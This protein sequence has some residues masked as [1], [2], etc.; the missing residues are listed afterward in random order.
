MRRRSRSPRRH[1]PTELIDSVPRATVV[2][3][4]YVLAALSTTVPV[5]DFVKPTP[6]VLSTIVDAMVKMPAP[7]CCTPSNPPPAVP[8]IEPP[9]MV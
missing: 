3:P 5:P 1:W 4:V 2:A 9:V 6:P 7:F 8:V